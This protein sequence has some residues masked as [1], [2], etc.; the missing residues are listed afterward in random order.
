MATHP[1]HQVLHLDGPATCS[2]P[3][4]RAHHRG[5]RS[6]HTLDTRAVAAPHDPK[7]STVAV[8][9]GQ[10]GAVFGAFHHVQAVLARQLNQQHEPGGALEQDRERLFT[11]L[12]ETSFLAL[13]KNL[14]QP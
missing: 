10:R 11:L 12:Y 7:R 2:Y 9:A 6:L 1:G 5:L 14:Q 13:R 4:P 3:V 8:P